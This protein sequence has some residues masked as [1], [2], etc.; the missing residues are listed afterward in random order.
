M[1]LYRI[2]WPNEQ[3]PPDP[4]C[5]VP[6]MEAEIFMEG[7]DG[8]ACSHERNSLC[9]AKTPSA[10]YRSVRFCQGLCSRGTEALSEHSFWDLRTCLHKLRRHEQEC[11][12]RGPR[13]PPLPCRKLLPLTRTPN[14]SY[15]SRESSPS[16]LPSAAL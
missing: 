6:G 9:E 4:S 5:S 14:E 7:R 13:I 16:D 12:E 3:M 10:M 15:M 1:S 8:T 11:L 2:S